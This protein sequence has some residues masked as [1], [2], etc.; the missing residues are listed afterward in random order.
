MVVQFYV[1]G[2]LKRIDVLHSI[3]R[4]PKMP[5]ELRLTRVVVG[6]VLILQFAQCSARRAI[7]VRA[8]QDVEILLVTHAKGPCVAGHKR[9]SLAYL[10]GPHVSEERQGR[11]VR[12]ITEALKNQI[13]N[14]PL[15]HAVLGFLF[16][17]FST[18]RRI[19][20]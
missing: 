6:E 10:R 13:G 8:D 1:A 19:E 5:K 18:R 9:E 16:L 11:P 4:A 2:T 3:K 17:K 12:W 15:S 20:A 14:R 7:A